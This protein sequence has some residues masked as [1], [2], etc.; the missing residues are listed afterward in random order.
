MGNRWG[1]CMGD[2]VS[3]E[4]IED[5]ERR[6]ALEMATADRAT[7]YAMLAELRQLTKKDYSHGTG[8][9]E[10]NWQVLRLPNSGPG[11]DS[12]LRTLEKTDALLLRLD[13]KGQDE[14]ETSDTKEKGDASTS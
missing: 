7:L 2:L 10:P 11:R 14:D 1:D 12:G 13:A 6:K 9:G 8:Q 3:C 5:E 4:T